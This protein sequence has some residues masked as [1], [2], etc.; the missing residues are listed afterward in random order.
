MGADRE[1]GAMMSS[2]DDV[3]VTSLTV[4]E[5]VAH[6]VIERPAKRN[7]MNRAVLDGL[8]EHARSVAELAGSGSVGAVV[9]AGRGGHLSAGLD[10]ADLAGLTMT[11]LSLD[12]VARVQA[13]FTAFEELDVPVLAAIDGVCLGAGLQLALACHVRGVTERASLAVLEPRWGLVPD[14]GASW[15]LPRLVGQGR[16]IELMLSARR[17]DAEWAI[18]A[19]LAEVRLLGDD[20]LADGHEVAVRWADGPQVLQHLP[21]LVREAVGATRDAALDAEARLQLRMLAGGDVSEALRAAA[22]GRAPRFGGR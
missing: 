11:P 3:A 16:A 14:L 7:A 21:R 19:G 13:V 5:R 6:V 20:A 18:G 2:G 8:L 17:V 10:L 1:Q 22:E 4:V 15:R 9:V 12:D